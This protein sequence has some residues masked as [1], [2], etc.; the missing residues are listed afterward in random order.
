MYSCFVSF[1]IIGGGVSFSTNVANVL[2]TARI[3]AGIMLILR[4]QPNDGDSTTMAFDWSVVLLT[5]TN[6]VVAF[7]EIFVT[8]KTFLLS[9][10]GCVCFSPATAIA[11]RLLGMNRAPTFWTVVEWHL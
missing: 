10:S 8:F 3:I 4:Q 1:Q 7:L 11:M 9:A 5:V 2:P 6:K